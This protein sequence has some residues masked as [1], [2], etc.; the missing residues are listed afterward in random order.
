LY[1][2][3]VCVLVGAPTGSGKTVA[4]ELSVL[5][6]IEKHRMRGV[7][8]DEEGSEGGEKEKDGGGEKKR[9]KIVYIGPMKALVH[10]RVKDWRQKFEQNLGLQIL[11]LTGESSPS[12]EQLR[13]ADILC[14]T[15]EKWDGTS[16][17][18]RWG[19]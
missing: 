18:V 17:Q 15:P 11:E 10:E 7:E 14:T 12:P 13:V 3:D 1:H 19:R 8:K 5:R 9:G 2:T 6:M 4:A 16:R